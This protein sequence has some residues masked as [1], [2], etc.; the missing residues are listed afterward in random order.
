MFSVR[1]TGNNGVSEI[2]VNKDGTPS[3]RSGSSKKAGKKRSGR[4]YGISDLPA[5]AIA[6]L[7]IGAVGIAVGL[8]ILLLGTVRMTETKGSWNYVESQAEPKK[9]AV[10]PG[11][12]LVLGG[13]GLL[14]LGAVFVGVSLGIPLNAPPTISA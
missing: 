1:Q 10:R 14:L 13:A 6:V 11:L 8:T 2:T 9:G 12:F 4:A 3:K 5:W 7:T